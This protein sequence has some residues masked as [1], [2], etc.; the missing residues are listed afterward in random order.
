MKRVRVRADRTCNAC[1]SAIPKG[2]WAFLVFHGNS[3]GGKTKSV[4]YCDCRGEMYE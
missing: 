3:N 4:W 2:A 1:R